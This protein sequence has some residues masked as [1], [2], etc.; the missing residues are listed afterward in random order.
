MALFKKTPFLLF[1]LLFPTFAFAS[2]IVS[3]TIHEVYDELGFHNGTTI[4]RWD[5]TVHSDSFIE[6]DVLSWETDIDGYVTDDGLAEAIDV[7]GDGEISFFDPVVHVFRDEVEIN[8]RNYLTYLEH[9]GDIYPLAFGG[10]ADGSISELDPYLPIDLVAGDYFL[11]IATYEFDASGAGE[12]ETAEDG[13][14]PRTCLPENLGDCFYGDG[15]PSGDYQI[16]F[17]GDLSLRNVQVNS[18]PVLMLVMPFLVYLLCIRR[19]IKAKGIK[20]R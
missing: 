4:D 17:T 7:N 13:R 10:A 15:S 11:V 1:I 2:I 12:S 5:F 3:G 6:I 9:S 16:T 19:Y 18:S 14:P 20:A 8:R